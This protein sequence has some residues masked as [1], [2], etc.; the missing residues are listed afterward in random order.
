M[1]LKN[2]KQELE[3]VQAK[4]S[5]SK[6][7]EEIITLAQK[8]ILLSVELKVVEELQQEFEQQ[9]QLAVNAEAIKFA[10]ILK[11]VREAVPVPEKKIVEEVP[12]VPVV[13]E[14]KVEAVVA[15]EEVKVT[16][17]VAEEKPLVKTTTRP[18]TLSEKMQTD[19]KSLAAKLSKS[20][21]KDLTKAISIN[22]K[23]LFAK[24][25]FKGDS[26]AFNEVVNQLNSF[27]NKEEA[28]SYLKNDLNA[29]YSFKE[30]LDSFI[31]FVELIERRYV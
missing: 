7:Y 13:T 9:K 12:V 8:A 26:F 29:K 19:D 17:K 16:E 30:G 2:K 24:E 6:S 18:A 5:E 20:P 10:E 1:D 22:Q 23:I 25:L 31:Q 21:I 27:Q 3:A 14:N 11:Q 15:V 4:I 28:L